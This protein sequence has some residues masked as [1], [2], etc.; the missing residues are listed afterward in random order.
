MKLPGSSHF[1]KM[2][3]SQY[4][5]ESFGTVRFSPAWKNSLAPSVSLDEQD[6]G[7]GSVRS[8]LELGAAILNGGS[9]GR[10]PHEVASRWKK[11]TSGDD[12]QSYSSPCP[13]NLWSVL[14]DSQEILSH[15]V[16]EIF[17]SLI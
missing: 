3:K 13:L 2:S 16:L 12:G 17:G 1:F 10:E 9:K 5:L 8:P 11:R 15:D 7:G 6:W 4:F 14:Q